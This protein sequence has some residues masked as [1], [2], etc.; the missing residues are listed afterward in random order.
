M[1]VRVN[2]QREIAHIC[3]RA[4]THKGNDS[5]DPVK[6]ESASRTVKLFVLS[7][8]EVVKGD[9]ALPGDSLLDWSR[10]FRLRSS[11]LSM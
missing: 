10:Q 1:T 5:K 8:K 4:E 11:F 9:Y 6:D 3:S 2:A 7:P